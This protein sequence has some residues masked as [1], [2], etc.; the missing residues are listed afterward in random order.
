MADLSF[1]K[2]P[3]TK[4]QQFV[5]TMG[6]HLGFKLV[7]FEYIP[8]KEKDGNVV[9]S[10]SL[11]L[12]FANDSRETFI[13]NIFEPPAK[14]EDIKYPMKHYENNVHTRNKTAE[15]QIAAEFNERFYLFDQLAKAWNSSN[16]RIN[17]FKST[18]KGDPDGL[19]KK[20]VEKFFSIF[21]KDF[22]QDKK[23][24]LKLLFKNNDV[25]QTSFL[26]LAKP[27]ASNFVFAPYTTDNN[28]VLQ[29]SSWEEKNCMRKYIPQYKAPDKAGGGESSEGWKPLKAA[30]GDS[31]E[32]KEL[33]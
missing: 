20:M 18:V 2:L 11:K 22:W 23:I 5:R 14:P 6:I 12:T 30:D 27:S 7:S 31:A 8:P 15:E 4:E 32:D 24:N 28:P 19:F 1:D 17:A 16:E 29:I 26:N 10:A 9:L 21:P 33:F 13:T 25:K 3:E